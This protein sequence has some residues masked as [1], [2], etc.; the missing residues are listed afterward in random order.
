[1]TDQ[2][3]VEIII[4]ASSLP[5]TDKLVH[6][7]S[8]ADDLPGA[9]EKV[10]RATLKPYLPNEEHSGLHS[11]RLQVVAVV[12]VVSHRTMDPMA[13]F[14]T[15]LAKL[16]DHRIVALNARSERRTE[17]L[18]ELTNDP[19]CLLVLLVPAS[20]GSALGFQSN[21]KVKRV[22]YLPG[23]IPVNAGN[24]RI[25]ITIIPR[26]PDFFRDEYHAHKANN[27]GVTDV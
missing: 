17:K 21:S 14:K 26:P 12:P 15:D 25:E 20:P 11:W 4:D 10:M 8:E 5:Y 9:L 7:S 23:Y 22:D 19:A 2:P 18:E 16:Q 3:Y 1:M 27:N 24:Q 13:R 6:R